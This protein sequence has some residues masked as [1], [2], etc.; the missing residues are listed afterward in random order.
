MS[1][2]GNDDTLGLRDTKGEGG[3]AIAQN[4]ESAENDGM[5]RSAIAT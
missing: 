1:G 5:P 3:I 2:T 4:P